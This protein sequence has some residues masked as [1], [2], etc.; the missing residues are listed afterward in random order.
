MWEP[1]VPKVG[2][3]LPSDVSS[4]LNKLEVTW[5]LFLDPLMLNLYRNELTLWCT[6]EMSFMN[7]G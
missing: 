5:Y 6:F 7:L 4:E 2:K 3:Y 1:S